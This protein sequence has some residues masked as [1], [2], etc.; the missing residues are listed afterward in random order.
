[1]FVVLTVYNFMTFF[2]FFS[3]N[4]FFIYHLLLAFNLE[5]GFLPWNNLTAQSGYNSC[6]L[7][8]GL[9]HVIVSCPPPSTCFC[10][11]VFNIW[12]FYWVLGGWCRRL[13][14]SGNFFFKF[15]KLSNIFNNFVF[16]SLFRTFIFR[17]LSL[18]RLDFELI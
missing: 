10:D 8:G 2:F 9:S 16:S 15:R 5:T 13:K 7:Y 12:D 11:L 14:F 4:G 1:M 18:F 6:F 3:Y 17:Y